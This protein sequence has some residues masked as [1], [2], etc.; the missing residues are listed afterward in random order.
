MGGLENDPVPDVDAAI[1]ATLLTQ[2]SPSILELIKLLIEGRAV[3][4]LFLYI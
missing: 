1:Y 3:S 4:L 2:K